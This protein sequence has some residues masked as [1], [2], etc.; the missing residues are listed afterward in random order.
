LDS[1]RAVLRVHFTFGLRQCCCVLKGLL[2]LLADFLNIKKENMMHRGVT[3]FLCGQDML[4]RQALEPA[5]LIKTLWIVLLWSLVLTCQA[6]PR[7]EK[8]WE[9]SWAALLTTIRNPSMVF[10]Y[11]CHKKAVTRSIAR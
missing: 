1:G 4:Q 7:H 3:L 9:L 11:P 2:V 10:H 5:L 8:K 6:G